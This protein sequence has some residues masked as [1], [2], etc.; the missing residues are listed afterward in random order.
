VNEPSFVSN[1]AVLAH[2]IVQFSLLVA[3]MWK[4]EFFLWADQIYQLIPLSDPFFPD[5]LRSFWT[6]RLAFVF[7]VDAVLIGIVAP[8]RLRIVCA[9]V[10]FIGV[11][12][13]CLHQGS[14]NDM[15]FLTAWWTS[16]WNLWFVWRIEDD[17]QEVL[18]RRAALLGRVII[19]MI[20][21]GGAVGKWTTEFWSGE[22]FWDIYFR[23]CDFWFFNLFRD[24]LAEDSLRNV[25]M[26]YSRIVV[27]VETIAGF[28]LWLLPAKWAAGVAVCLLMSIAIFS[29]FYLISV[30]FSLV[31]LASVGFLVNK[32]TASD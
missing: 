32:Q 11:S 3:L 23:G 28:G 20:F 5:C 26:W 6:L 10:T 9:V 24:R 4:W 8:S 22:V 31:G 30:V 29:N 15:T 25:A 12:V 14:Y 13:L 21:L 2:R 17:D 19:S 7:T 1:K 16:L 18:M 27:A